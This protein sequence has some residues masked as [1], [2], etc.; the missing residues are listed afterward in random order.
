M[1][2]NSLYPSLYVWKNWNFAAIAL[3]QPCV[4]TMANLSPAVKPRLIKEIN[5][6]VFNEE[7]LVFV[8]KL[9]ARGRS[10]RF[11]LSPHTGEGQPRPSLL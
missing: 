1:A 10:K 9:H 11:Q 7:N 4:I 8:W 3:M 2:L 5:C 6:Q